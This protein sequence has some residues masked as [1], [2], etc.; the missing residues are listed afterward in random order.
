MISTFKTPDEVNKFFSNWHDLNEAERLQ[1][2]RELRSIGN[3][4]TRVLQNIETG[5]KCPLN[6]FDLIRACK[7]DSCHYYIGPKQ[8][9]SYSE[10][11]AK[12]ASVCKNC[13]INCLEKTKNNRLS[14]LEVATLLGISISEVNNISTQTV[15]KV[16]RAAIKEAL[17][18]FQVPKYR[19]LT[20]HCINCEVSIIDELE[21]GLKPELVMVP[22]EYGWCSMRCK[23]SKPKWQFLIEREF[24]CHYMDALAIGYTVYKNIETLGHVYMVTND[25]LKGLKKRIVSWQHQYIR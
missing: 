11:Q 17:E 8:A 25:V 18:K 10:D 15:A 14:A 3:L 20:G 16:R 6:N 19:Y 13:M 2:I 21:M 5:F 23:D 24:S 9:K 22:Y 7:L 4:S 1:A 12:A